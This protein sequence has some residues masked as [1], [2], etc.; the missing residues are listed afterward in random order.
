MA[1]SCITTKQRIGLFSSFRTDWATPRKLFQSLNDEFDFKLDAC[2]TP[3]SACVPRFYSSEGLTNPWADPTFCNPPYGR[4]I[5]H[6]VEKGYREA[7]ERGN[8]VV[9][10]LPSRTD[11]SWWHNYCM[12]A[13]E[14]RFLRGRLY[15]DDNHS[16]GS[17]APFPSAIIV[18]RSQNPTT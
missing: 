5:S 1:A 12:N 3:E 15:F 9:M 18:F 2:A 11:T 10:L 17:R 14:I 4:K 16:Q 13:C 6:W 7:T 8:T